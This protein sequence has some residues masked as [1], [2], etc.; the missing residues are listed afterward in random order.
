VLVIEGQKRIYY[1]LT[2]NIAINNCFNAI[3]MNG[4]V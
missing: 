2:G 1:A 4:A 3:A